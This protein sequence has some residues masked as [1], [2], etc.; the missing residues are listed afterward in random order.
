MMDLA[1][2]SAEE[3]T[4]LL[5]E[6]AWLPHNGCVARITTAGEGNMNVVRR[7]HYRADD[8]ETNTLIL[9]QSV[10]FVAKYPDIPAP[11]DRIAVEAAFY[12]TI[13][14]SDALTR[15]SPNVVGFAAE[16]RLLALTDAGVGGDFTRWY[17]QPDSSSTTTRVLGA[18]T[19][20]LGHLHGLTSHSHAVPAASFI[21]ADMRALNHA[22][23]FDIPFAT[24]NGLDLPEE[25]VNF[26]AAC[27]AEPQVM[28]RI[29]R[30]GEMYLGKRPG[31]NP[32]VLLHGDF[33]PGS[34]VQHPSLDAVVLDP[35][36]AFVG[37]AEFD[38]GVLNA[39]LRLCG[40]D[41][42]VD[43]YSSKQPI[44]RPLLSAFAGVEI[45]RRLLGVAQLPLQADTKQRVRW[46]VEARDDIMSLP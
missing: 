3:L 11:A 18:V 13:R 39:H 12:Q 42:V 43:R 35:E 28:Q 46:L 4:T 38:L 16:H 10:P 15:R 29:E 19:D 21:N 23:I 5:R 45:M 1:S 20:W 26:A 33:Y 17:T 34:W 32:A 37:P 31:P 14:A 24:N 9:K 40:L 8:K 22:H 7:I 44:D 30:L 25:L 41:P 27:R 36:F 2:A 6:L